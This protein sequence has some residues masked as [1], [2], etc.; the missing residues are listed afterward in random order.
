MKISDIYNY[1]DTL[2]PFELQEKWDNSGLI[3]GNMNEEVL[4][5]T[6]SI[7][8]DEEQLLNTK[9]NSLIIVH[10]PLIFSGLKALDYQAYPAALLKVMVQKNISCIAMHTNFDKTHLNR[11]VAEKIL[12]FNIASVD[13]FIVYMDV[14]MSFEELSLHVKNVFNLQHVKCVTS[15]S[16][17]KRLA[18]TTGAGASLIA[19]VD[20]DCFLT[21]DIKYHDAMDAKVRK[22]ALIDI[23]HFESECFFADIL[24]KELENLDLEVIISSS[25]NPFT[26]LD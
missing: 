10:H 8:I 5:V 20:A 3:V 17:I 18:L 21:G 24:S 1:L 9:E 11:Y 2:S 14:D 7:D 6:V 12:G 22:L 13:D 15:S 16:H 23:N 19:E 26:Y 4:H 25:K